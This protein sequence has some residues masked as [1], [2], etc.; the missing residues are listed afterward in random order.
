MMQSSSHRDV[1]RIPVVMAVIIVIVWR[2]VAIDRPSEFVEIPESLR[3]PFLALGMLFLLCGFLI[4]WFRPNRWSVV[5]LLY[6][7]GNGIHW[8]G[9]IGSVSQPTAVILFFLYLSLTA[10]ADAALFHLALIFPGGK[11]I[12]RWATSVLYLPAILSLILAPASGLLN[13]AVLN[14][15]AGL[16]L[17]IANL[18]SVI[19]GV[20]FL[21]QWIRV[22]SGIRRASGLSLIACSILL[23]GILSLLGAGGVLPGIPDAWNLTLGL[24][25]MALAYALFTN[26]LDQMTD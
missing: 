24:I 9:A 21:V 22:S 5:F 11:R 26:T 3:W 6:G 19:A 18:L 25:P 7:I 8:G 10:L 13:R 2:I 16:V 12:P 23:S 4:W 15:F 14:S 20:L 17:L 1:F